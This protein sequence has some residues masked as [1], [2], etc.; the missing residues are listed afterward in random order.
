MKQLFGSFVIAFS[1]YSRIPMPRVEWTKERMRYALCFFPWIGVLIGGTELLLFSGIGRL[2]AAEQSAGLLFFRTGFGLAVPLLIT[3]GIHM[4]G[5]LDVTDARHSYGSREKKLE[6]LSDPHIGAFA[7]IGLGVYFLL[8]GAAFSVLRW[9]EIRLLAFIFV[10]E[11]AL[12]GLSVVWFPMA[13]KDGLAVQFSDGA[14][15]RTVRIVMAA[16]LFFGGGV[17]LFWGRLTGILCLSTLGC[18]FFR[19]YRMSLN[20]FGGITGDLAGFFLQ[21]CERNAVIMLAL[22]RLLRI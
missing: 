19:Y 9:E 2:G 21:C 11:R 8:Y 13:K 1:M 22:C 4:D 17:L 7:V 3:G 10:L 18:T 20:E 12:S 5:Y 15:K 6:I 16:Y 14:V